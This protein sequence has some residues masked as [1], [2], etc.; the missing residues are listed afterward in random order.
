MRGRKGRAGSHGDG[1]A[2]WERGRRSWAGR[3]LWAD[4]EAVEALAFVL[5]VSSH[6]DS[7]IK[8]VTTRDYDTSDL[9]T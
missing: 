6:Y 2:A 3:V 9:C 4:V 8:M 5:E 7:E 1:H